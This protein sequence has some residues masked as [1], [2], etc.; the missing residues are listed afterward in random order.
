MKPV[1]KIRAVQELLFQ[2]S[3]EHH[4]KGMNYAKQSA[5]C[6]H[7]ADLAES[8]SASDA[9]RVFQVFVGQGVARMRG[10]EVELIDAQEEA[11]TGAEMRAAKAEAEV[12]RLREVLAGMG[13]SISSGGGVA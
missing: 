2:K 3:A 11:R 7:V 8:A 9:E 4:V 6:E 10:G 13:V 1:D 12:G 5:R